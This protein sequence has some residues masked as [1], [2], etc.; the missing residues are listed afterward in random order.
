QADLRSQ[1]RIG[2]LTDRDH[3]RKVVPQQRLRWHRD[4]TASL[5]LEQIIAE[6]RA[7]AF[8]TLTSVRHHGFEVLFIQSLFGH[9]SPA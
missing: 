3:S 1:Y 7:P 6:N 4:G 8:G 2:N 5:L 9:G